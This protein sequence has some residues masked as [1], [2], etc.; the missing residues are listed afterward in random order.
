[1]S[2][3]PALRNL[4]TVRVKLEELLAIVRTNRDEHRAIYEDALD[5]W[6]TKVTESLEAAYLAAKE[7]K[8]Y[9][10][11]FYLPQPEDHTN[12][13]N[14]AIKM[15]EMSQDDELELSYAEFRQFVMDE[16]GWQRAFLTASSNYTSTDTASNKLRNMS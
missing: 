4:Q 12:D 7:G 13:Y 11:S 2:D 6:K 5:G 8:D 9:N 3:V 15:L 10:V 16:W 1:M 14:V